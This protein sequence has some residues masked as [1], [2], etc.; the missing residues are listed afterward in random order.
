[1]FL[2]DAIARVCGWVFGD[3]EVATH[4]DVT[5]VV[6]GVVDRKGDTWITGDIA[7]LLLA[8]SCGKQDVVAVEQKPQGSTLRTAVGKQCG[9]DS[10]VRTLKDG[11]E[12]LVGR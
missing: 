7:Q 1:M 8:G 2:H 4:F 9:E 10:G 12:L 5:H 3:H 6:D 11:E